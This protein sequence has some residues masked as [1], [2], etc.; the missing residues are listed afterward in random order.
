MLYGIRIFLSSSNEM[1]WWGIRNKDKNFIHPMK[2][3][4][5][6]NSIEETEVFSHKAVMTWEIN[7]KRLMHW[8]SDHNVKQKCPWS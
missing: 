4:P 7:T 2:V 6:Y 3:S 8:M 1:D 5:E